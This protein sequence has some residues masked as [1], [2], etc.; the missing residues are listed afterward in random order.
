MTSN[1]GLT[2]APAIA[3]PIISA[4]IFWAAPQSAEPAMK[5][6]T[7]YKKFVR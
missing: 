6:T 2:P 5:K 3:R 4:F 1:T 7:F